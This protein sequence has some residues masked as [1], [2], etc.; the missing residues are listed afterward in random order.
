MATYRLIAF[1]IVVLWLVSGCAGFDVG[2][3]Q[4]PYVKESDLEGIE[5]DTRQKADIAKW[6]HSSQPGLD[7][8]L[9]LGTLITDYYFEVALFAVPTH[10]ETYSDGANPESDP[11]RLSLN[12]TPTRPGFTLDASRI[13]LWVDG[14]EYRPV[15]MTKSG[16][17]LKVMSTFHFTDVAAPHLFSVFFD[18]PEKDTDGTIQLDLSKAIQGKTPLKFPLIKFRKLKW[19][20]GYS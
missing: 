4:V 17:E 2:T 5:L 19:S 14:R 10:L 6:W 18:V 1:L 11:L 8:A 3:V 13:I 15:T 7:V 16:S 12:I 9:S 20:E